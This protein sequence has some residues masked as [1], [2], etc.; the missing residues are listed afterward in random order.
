MPEIS[1]FFGIIMRMRY[2]D[3]A[4]PHFHVYS[5]ESMAAIGLRPLRIL[6][7]ELRPRV[8][9]LVIERAA[10]HHDELLVDWDLARKRLPL[11]KIAP[12]V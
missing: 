2:N 8:L 7:G 6:E 9:G 10:L 12:L 1:R 11:R 5:G 3:H 4:P